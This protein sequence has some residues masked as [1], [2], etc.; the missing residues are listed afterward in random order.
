MSALG[1][2]V[3]KIVYLVAICLL[4]AVLY[5]LSHPSTVGIGGSQADPGG[6]LAQIRAES[7]LS[8]ADLGEIDPTGETIKLATL[9]M[10]GVAANILWEKAFRYKKKKDWTNRIRL[11]RELL[12]LLKKNKQITPAAFKSLYRKA[13]GGFFRSKRHLK[14][15]MQENKLLK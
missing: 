7:G 12:K 9:G 5:P 8:E 11:Q 1:P 13:K 6:R 4:L 10:R 3:R 14:L 2:F 15:Y